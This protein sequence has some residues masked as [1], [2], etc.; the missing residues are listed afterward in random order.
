M[1]PDKD[2]AMIVTG[3]HNT[4]ILAM[5]AGNVDAA[6]IAVPWQT[7]A[8]RAGFHK[9]A[10]FGDVMRMPMAG[11]G[12]TEENIKSRPEIL[13]RA[14]KATLR[15]ID[16]VRDPKNKP[17]VLAL[18]GGWF[19]ISGD[20]AQEAYDQMVQ[21]YPVSGTVSDEALE[22]DL[23]VAKQAGAIKGTVPVSK[24]VD[25]QFVKAARRELTIEK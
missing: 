22:K 9:T 3:D 17:S 6:V 13:K 14:V 20:L 16:F 25:F 19:K 1:D 23:E 5:Q 8:V 11:L 10:Y 12:A 7:V 21:A 15:G 2:V 24:V 18:M 4:S